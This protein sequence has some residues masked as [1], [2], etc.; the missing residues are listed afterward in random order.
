MGGT[1]FS[2]GECASLPPLS[3][4]EVIDLTI[5]MIAPITDGYFEGEWRFITL[6]GVLCGGMYNCLFDQRN[7]KVSK[8]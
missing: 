1:N 6:S 3:P 7:N 4:N 8:L 2:H 5:T